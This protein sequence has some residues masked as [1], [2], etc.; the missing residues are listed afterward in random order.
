MTL[1]R[2]HSLLGNAGND[3]KSPQDG[4]ENGRSRAKN[5][6][7][8]SSQRSK[9]QTADRRLNHETLEKRELLAAEIGVE[10]HPVFAPGTPMETIEAWEEEHHHGLNHITS[11]TKLPGFQFGP[12]LQP[13]LFNPTDPLRWR[14][15]A[16]NPNGAPDLGDPITLTWSIVPDGTPMVDPN[17]GNTTGTSNL[18][19]FLDSVYGSGATNEITEKPW[20]NIFANVYDVWSYGTGL[21][22]VYEDDDDQAPWAAGASIGEEDI[23]AD[24][25]IAGAPIDGDYNVLAA[26]YPPYGYGSN[27]LDGDMII[28]TADRYYQDTANSAFDLNI[29]LTNILAHEIGHGL[30]LAHVMPTNGTKL[31]EPFI[32][33]NYYG[34]QED[35][36][37]NINMLYGDALEPNDSIAQAVP[38]GVLDL[39][40][41]T[42]TDLT[43]DGPNSDIDVFSFS[44]NS[45]TEIDLV[46]T[47][48]GSRYEEGEQ[49][50]SAPVFVDRLRQQDLQFRLLDSLG[51]EI[52]LSN[53][54]AVGEAEFRT[55]V[56][57]AE[58]DYAIEVS[59]FSGTD[60]Q[61][62]R[63]SVGNAARVLV[64]PTLLAIRPDDSGLLQDGDTLNVAPNEFNLYFNGGADLDESSITTDTVKLIRA[65]A[66]G[67]FGPN[68][69]NLDIN[70]QPIDDDIEVELGYVGLLEAG[71]IEA[72][73]LQQIILR[74]ASSAAHNA[75]D[76]AFS[77][78]DDLYKIVLVGEGGSPL[79]SRTSVPF[80]GGNNFETTFRLN[81]GSQVVAVVPQP[82]VRSNATQANPEGVLS[83]Q[84]DTIVVHFDGQ[85]LDTGDAE[86]PAFYRLIDTRST[87]DKSDDQLASLQPNLA[88]YD[89]AAGTVTLQFA[90]PIPEGN[91]RLDIGEANTPIGGSPVV[92][93]P[94][95]TGNDN[96]STL[97]TASDLTGTPAVPVTLDST[98][99]R[100]TSQIEVQT[101]PLAQRVGG[102]DEPGHR[103]IQREAHVG[104]D[105]GTNLQLPSATEIVRYYFPSTLGVDTNNQ[106]YINLITEKEKEIVRTI[107]DIYAAV[108]GYEFIETSETDP[109]ADQ[110]MIGKG[111]FRAVSPSLGPDDGVAGLANNTFAILNGSIFNQSNRF[112]GDGF[113]EVMVHEIGHSLGLGHS[114]DIPSVQGAG[115]PN[116]VLPGDHDIV[117]LQRVSPPNSTD[118]DLYKFAVGETG[119]FTAETFAERL[120]MPS[121]LSTVLTLFG[122]K[123]DGTLEVIARN[124][125]YFGNDS[126]IDVELDAGTYLIGVTSTENEDYNPLVSDSGFGGT[127]DGEYELELK[128]KGD[129]ADVLRDVDGTPIDGDRDGTPGG[130]FS[131]YFQASDSDTTVFVDRLNDPNASAF[132]G[133]GTLGDAFDN[134][135]QALQRA[136]NRIVFPTVGLDNLDGADTFEI[137]QTIN[138]TP[139]NESFHFGGGGISLAPGASPED[140][141]IATAAAIDAVLPG[142]ATAVGRTVELTNIDRLDLAGSDLLL[143]TP[144]LVR[145]VGNDADGDPATTADIK[146][147]LVGTATSGAALRDGAEFR[148]PQGVTAMIDAGALIKMR[149]SNLD[150]GSSSID[151]DRSAASLQLLGTPDTPVWLRSYFDSTF[152][153]NS[154]GSS[155]PNPPSAGDFGGIVFR[156]DS[157]L[158]SAGMFLNYISHADI[159]HGGGKVFVDSNEDSFSPI[160]VVDARPT[161]AF[162]QI[163]DSNSAAV[164]ASPDS[165][166]ESGGRIGPDI[167]GNY[168]AGNTINGL[169]IRI[170]TEDGEVI[171]KLTTPG[172]FNDTDIAHVLTENLVIAGNVGGRYWDVDSS[173]LS[174]RASGRLLVDPGI[175]IKSSGSR[176]EAEAGGS[177]I[178]AEGTENRPVI[179]TSLS[180][181]RYGGSG[182]F[183]TTNTPNSAG[184]AGDWGG[185]YF[186]YTSSGSIDNA[187]ISYGGGDS[188]IEGGSANFNL[189][190]IHQAEVRI[191]NSLISDNADGNA[192][193]NRNGRGNNQAATI[194]VRGSQPIIV[195]NQFVDNAGPSISIN[196]NSLQFTNQPD[197]GRST[198]ELNPFS[199]FDDNVGPL[200]RLNQFENNGINGMLVRGEILTTETIWDDTDIVHVLQNEIVV[201]NHHSNSGLTLRSSGSESLVVKLQG[202]NAGFTA[203]GSPAEIIDRIGGTVTVSGAPGFPVILTS[204]QDDSVGAGFTPDGAF[205][206]DT[207]NDG[208]TGGQ[209]GDWRGLEFDEFSNDRNVAVV[210]ERETPLT[211]GKDENA[212]PGTAQFVGTLAPNQKSGDENRRLGFEIQGFISPDSS[213]DLDV[214]SFE[215]TAGTPVWLDIDRT[216][217]SLDS[218]IE[219]LNAN[220]TVI[221]RSMSSFDLGEA[222]TLNALPL[223]QNPLLGGD[224]NSENFRDPGLHFVLP[225]TVGNVGRYFVRVRS[226]GS[227]PTSLDGVSSGQYHMQIRLQQ[228]DEYPGS[229]VQYAD[230]RY[231]TR[232]IDVSGL[233]ARSH[234]LGEAGEATAA[235]N[236]FAQAQPLQSLLQSDMAAIS[237][238]GNLG[239]EQGVADRDLDV[240]WYRFDATQTG[241]QEISGVNDAAGTISVVFDMDYADKANRGDT[242]LA[243]YDA[244]GQLIF[245]GR[246]SNIEDDQPDSVDPDP[247]IDDLS[248]GSLGTK[249][250]YIGPVHLISGGEYYIAVMGNG[251]TPNALMG[252]YDNL[253]HFLQD[254]DR[255][256]IADSGA[257]SEAGEIFVPEANADNRYVRLE[258]VNSV[259]RVVEDRIGFSGYNTIPLDP[260]LPNGV[261]IAPQTSIFNIDS[262]ADLQNHLPAF[263]LENV[264]LY[265]ATDRPLPNADDQLYIADPFNGGTYTKPVSPNNW[266]A[267]NDDIQDITIRSDGRMFG[268]Q[269][270]S[271]VG[272]SV[273]QLVE[274]NPANGALTVV[275][276]D[277]IPGETPAINAR[278]LNANLTNNGNRSTV[279][280]PRLEEF[281]N[282]D[283]VDALTFERTGSIT[284]TPDYDL[285]Y[286]V[287]ESSTSS[288]L[289]RATSDGDASPVAA[290][291]G[292]P[293]SNA[294]VKYGVMGNINLAGATYASS[295]FQVFTNGNNIARTNIRVQ[296]NQ[297]GVVG[298]FT[299]N[300]SRPNNG[301]QAGIGNV[302]LATR[303][304]NLVIGTD[305]NNG[306]PSAAAIVNAI[307]T[308]AEARQLVT[309]AIY[310]GNANNNGDGN[311]GTAANN[312]S[313]PNYVAGL[314]ASLQGRVT[315][316]SFDDPVEPTQMYGVTNAGE[317]ITIDK[318]TG[319][320]VILNQVVGQQFSALTL[321]PQSVENGAYSD[322]LFAT[323]TGGRLYAFDFTGTLQSIFVGGSDFVT[324]NDIA[325]ANG[326][327][328]VGLAFSPLDLNLWHPTTRRAN[329]VGHGINPAPDGSRTPGDIDEVYGEANAIGG[330]RTF[331]QQ[332]GG[333]S[334]Y[335]GLEEWIAENQFGNDTQGYITYEGLENAQYGL[336]EKLHRDLTSNPALVS[337]YAL[338]GGAQGQLVSNTFDLDGSIAE[339]RPTLYVNYFLETENHPGETTAN[340]QDPFRDAARVFVFRPSTNEWELVATNNSALSSADPSQT[341][342]GELPGFISHL[343]DAGLNSTTPRAEEHQIVQ[344]LFDN[345]GTWRQARIDLSSFA[346]EVGLQLRFD[347]ST[348]GRIAGD[349]IQTEFGEISSDSRANATFDNFFEGFYIDDI[350]VGYAERGE[351]VTVPDAIPTTEGNLQGPTRAI[352][353]DPSTFQLLNN[354]RFSNQDPNRNPEI[355]SGPYQVEIRRV[356]EYATLSDANILPDFDFTFQPFDTN[357]RHILSE[358]GV[359]M[360]GGTTGLLADQ[361]R[362]RQQGMF[363]IDSNFITDSDDVGISVQPGTAEETG[364]PHPG[365]LINF[366]QLNAS[367]LVPGV[368]IQNNVIAGDSAIRFEGEAS[369]EAGRPV[370]FG[371][372]VNNTLVGFGDGVGI[373]VV[374]RA[375]PTIINNI[376]SEFGTAIDVEGFNATNTVVRKNYFQGNASNGTTGTDPELAGP[377]APL[378]IDRASRNFYLAAGS[379]AIDNSQETLPDRLDFV[380]FKTELGISRSNIDAPQ[381]DV[382]GQLRV[383]SGQSG[384][385][386][387]ADPFIDQ[388]AIDRADTDAPYAVL[389]KPIDDDNAG[390]DKDPNATV[391][392]L[393][394]PILD[395]FSILIGDGRDENSPFEGTGIDPATVD[396]DSILIRRNNIELVE[397]VDYRLGFNGSTGELRLTPL[398]TLWQPNGVYEIILDNQRIADRAGNLLRPNQQ[399]G[400][401]KF[402]IILPT[403]DLDFGDAHDSFGT[404]LSSNG[405]RHAIIDNGLIR[406]GEKIDAEV[407]APGAG[408]S[409][410]DRKP[411]SIT[412]NTAAFQS[413]SVADDVST[414][415]AQQMPLL[416]DTMTIDIGSPVGPIT[417]E[418]VTV[419]RSAEPG[420]LSIVFDDTVFADPIDQMDQ[421]NAFVSDVHDAIAG[422]FEGFG[423]AF[424]VEV[425]PGD[426]VA[427]TQ[428]S[429]SLTNF[430]DEDGVGVGS[431]NT[432]RNITATATNVA[433]VVVSSSPSNPVSLQ[434]QSVPSNGDQVVIDLGTNAGSK[435]FEF[436]LNDPAATVPQASSSGTIAVRY[437][438][439]DNQDDI[440]ARLA[441]RIDQA[442]AGY[443]TSLVVS[444][445]GSVVTLTN[446][447]TAET[448]FV[449]SLA[450]PNAISVGVLG[451]LNPNNTNG[452]SI[453]INAPNGGFL[454][455]WIDWDQN[456]LF[457][458]RDSSETGGEQIFRSV[459]LSAGDNILN[460]VT[461]TTATAGLTTARFRISP[462]GGLASDGLAVGGEVEDYQ[463][464]VIP[465]PNPTPQDDRYDI[466]EDQSLLTAEMGLS[467]VFFG[468]T[469]AADDLLTPFAPTTVVLVDGPSHADS[470]TIDPLT[471]HFS[472]VPKT[473]FAGIDTFT[474]RLADQA[475]LIDNPVL[476]INGNPIGIATVTINVDP[477]N[478]V[479]SVE[480]LTLLALEDTQRTFTA[481]Q[482]KASA[483]GDESRDFTLTLPD[484]ST[485]SAPWDESIQTFNVIALHTTV[486]GVTTDITSATTT[487]AQGFKTP[488]GR[489][490]PNWDMMTG[491]LL[492]VDYL[493]DTDLNQDNANG[494]SLLRDD[495]QF[496]IEDDGELINPGQDLVD[497]SDDTTSTGP[498]L[499]ARA[500]AEIDVKPKNDA[501]VAAEDVI[502]ENNA[503]W[504]AFFIGPDPMNPVAPVPVPTEDQT[505]VI[506]HAY[507]IA[508]DKE[509][510]D[511]AAD[512]N[513]NT[514]DAGLT[515]TAVS[516]TSAL[517][518]TVSIDSNGDIVYTPALNTYGEDSFTYTVTDSGITFDLGP[519][520]MP[521][522]MME[523]DDFLSHTATVRILIKPVNDTPQADDLSLDLLEYREDADVTGGANPDPK[524]DGVGFK[525][526]SKDDLLRLGDSGSA[527]EVTP[528]ADFPADF[529][530]DAQDLRVIKI[531]LPDAA[532]ASVDARL[533]TYDAVTGLAPVQTLTTANGTLTLTFS[534]VAD[535]MNPG[536]FIA[537]SGE[538]VSGS[539]EPNVDYNEESPFDT[540]DLF[541]YF[542][543][544]FS[545]I[546]VP[547]AGNF[548]GE[549]LDSVGHGSLTSEAATVTMTT[550][551]TNDT[552][553]FPVF[554]TVTF[555]EDI[556]DAGDA[557]NTVIYDIYGESVIASADPAVHNLPQAIFV[558]RETAEDERGNSSGAPATQTLTY[559]YNP[560]Y[561]PAGMFNSDP[562]LDE[563]GVLTLT[564]N[565]DAYGYALYEVTMTDNGQSYDPNTGMLVDDFRSITRTLTIHITPVNDAPVTEDR[566]LEVMEVEEFSSPDDMPTGAVASID[567]TPEQ[568]L[569]GTTENTELAEQSDFTDD[570]DALDEFD[571]EEQSLRVVEF[572]VTLADGSTEVVNAENNNGVELTLATGRITFNFDDITAGGAYTGGTYFPNVDY[573]EES[574]FAPNEQFTYVV[575][576]FGVT[577]IPGSLDV[578]GTT[579]QVDYTNDG[580]SPPVGLNNRSTPRTMTLTTRAQ[581]DVPEFPIFGEVSFAEDINDAGDAFNTVFYDIYGEAVIA[582]ADPAVH[583]LPQAI[584]VS[585]ATAEDERGNDSGAL[586]TQN[587]SFSFATVY[588]PDGMFETTPTL[589]EYGVL[590]LTPRADAYGYAVFVVTLTDDGGSYNLPNDPRSINRTLTVHITPVNDAPVTFDR[591]LE[592]DEV[593]EFASPDDSPTGDVASI[594]L[595][596][597]QFL[598]GTTEN[599]ELAEQSDF[600][601][602]IDAVDEF[603]E[604]EQS[605]RVVEFTVT[606][607]DGSTEVVNA[608]NNNGVELT[609]AT[610]RI[611]FNFDDITAGGAY[612]GG[613]YFPN[614]DYNEE[615]PFAP[616]EQFTYVVEDFGTTSI[617]GS[618]FVNAGA[619]DQVDYTNDGGSPPVGLNNRST[620]RTMTLTTRAQNDVPEFP[621]FN[622]VTFAEDINDVGD[623]FNTVIYDIYG[624]SVIASAD[625]AVHNLPQAIF[626][627]RDTA[628]DERGNSSGAPA[629]QTLTYSYNPLY[630]PAG[631]FNSDP[632]LDEYGVLTLTPNADAY[633]YA[634]YEVTMTDNGQSYDPNTG[635][636]VDDFR[637][638]TRTLTIHITPVNDAPVTE[639]RALEVMEVEEFSSPD[640]L[641]TGAVASIDLTPEQFLGGTT[642]N[643]ELAEQSDFTDDMDAVDEFDEEEQSLRVVEFTVTLADGST[644]VVNAE[645][646]NGVEL[647]LLTGRI[648]F[649]FDDITAGGAYTGGIYFPNVDYNEES[650]FAPNEQFTYVVEDFGVTTIPGSL[651][652][653]GTTEQVDYTNDGGSPPVGLNNR[654]TPRT[655][656]LT[657]RAQNDAPEFP[658]FDTVTFAE[659]INDAG[660]AFNT[661]FYDIYSGNVVASYDPANPMRPQ[662]I[663]VSR[664]TALDERGDGLGFAPTQSLSY[665][666]TSLASSS[667]VGMFETLPTLDDFGVL[668]LTPR[669]DVYGW[670]V[671]EVTATDDGSS[672]DGAGGLVS[673]ARSIARTLTINIT[674]VNDQPITFDRDL[675]VTEVEEF[676]APDDL[677]TGAVA[678]LP[679]LP[680]DF[681]G[682]TTANPT[683]ATASDFS[684]ETVTFEEFDEDEQGL[685]VVEFQVRLA[686]GDPLT[687]NAT[688]YVNNTPITLV[689]GTISFEFDPVTGAFIEGEYLPSVDVN[690]QLPFEPTEVFS[691]I[692]EDFDPTSIPG[693]DRPDPD[694]TGA[695]DYTTVAGV[696]SNNRSAPRD[697]TLT[698]RAIN[699]VPEFPEFNTV[700]FAED[701][702]DEGAAFNTVFYDIYAGQVISTNNPLAHGLPQAIHP[703]RATALDERSVQEVSFSV[704]VVSAPSGM[705][706]SD[707]ILDRFGVLQLQPNADAYGY[708]VFTVTATDDGQSYINGSMQDSPRSVTRTLTVN[709]TPVNDQPV[710]Y[711]RELTV[712]EVE[713]FA[714]ITGLPTGRAA[715]LNLTPETFLE[716]TPDAQTA[717]FANGVVTTNE[718][719][720]DEQ[721][722]RVVQF[723]VTNA[724]GTPTVVNRDNLN[725][726]V[727][728]LATGT[729]TFNF[730]ASGAFT[731]GQYVPSVDYNQ[732]SP[733]DPF[734]RFSYIVEDFGATSIPGTDY[735][736]GQM[737]PPVAGFQQSDYT[738][739]GGVG[740]N[741]RSESRRVTI[742]TIQVNDAPRIEFRETV[743][744]R[745]R[746]D[747]RGTSLTD[748]AT[749][750]DPAE[751]TALDENT[752]QDVFFTFKEYVSQSVPDL[753]R[754]GFTPEVSDDGTLTVYPSPDAVGT[755][756]FVMLATD[757][758]SDTDPFSPKSVELTVTVNVRPV[759]DQPRLSDLAPTPLTGLADDQYEI[760]ADGTLVLTIKEDNTA[761]DGTT[762]MPYSIPLHSAGI[763]S[764]PGLLDIYTPGPAN[765][766]DGTLGGGQTVELV[767]FTT[768]PTTLGGSVTYIP[769]NG[770][771]PASLEYTP[772]TNINSLNNLPDSFTYQ[773]IDDGTNFNI[774]DQQLDSSP[775]TRTG[776]I[777][778]VLNP[779]NDRPQFDVAQTVINVSEDANMFVRNDFAFN[780]FGGPTP[781]ASDEFS[782]TS[783]Q[784]VSFNRIEPVN[785]SSTQAGQAFSTLPT[786]VPAGHLTFQAAPGVFG[787][788]VFDIYARDNGEGP[789]LGR[790]D[791]NESLAR[792]ITINVTAV[793]DAPIPANGTGDTITIST[794]EDSA[795][796]I[797][798]DGA[799]NGS[800][801]GNFIAGPDSPVDGLPGENDTQVLSAINV[802]LQTMMGGTLTPTPNGAGATAYVYT[803]PLNFVGTDQFVY[804]VSDGDLS[805]TTPATISLVVTPVNDAPIVSPLAPIVVE[806]S[807]GQVTLP[808]W[809]GTVL[810]GPPG[811]GAGGR[812]VDEFDGTNTT[813]AQTITEYRFAYVSGDTDLLQTSVGN[814]TGLEI[815]ANGSL[816]F[817]TSDENSGSATYQL[818]A[819][820]SGPND[821]ANGDVRESAPVEFTLTVADVN[822]LP[823]FTAGP[824]V[825]VLEDSGAY[826]QPWASDISA[827][828][829][830]EAGQTVAFL[831]QVP[832]EDQDLFAVQ[833]AID[834]N[835]VLTF[836][837]ADDAA[838]S[839]NVTVTLQDFDNG[840]FA[841]S[842][843]PVILP[844]TITETADLPVANDDSFTTTEDAVLFF[845]I[846]DLLANDSDP[847]LADSLNF[848]ELDT[849]TALGATVTINQVTGEIAY[850]PL[851]ADAIQALRPG[852]TLTDTFQYGLQD[853]SA[854]TDIVT[855][856]VTLTI[857]GRND[858][859]VVVNDRLFIESVGTTVLDQDRDPLANDSDIDGTLDR[860]SLTIVVEP[861]FGT[862][863]DDNGV[864]TYLPG[865]D[866]AGVD[867]FTYTIAD[868]LGQASAQATV[869]LQGRPTADVIMGGTSVGRTG[870]IDISDSFTTAFALDLSTIQIITQPSNGTADV[871]DGMIHYTPNAGYTGDDFLVFTVA[872]EN[873]NRS[874]PTRLNL[875]TVS[876]RL[877]NPVSFSDVNRNGEVT[878]LDALLIINR[879]NEVSGSSSAERIPVTDDDYGIGTN[880]GVDEQFYYDQS[881]DSFISSLDALRVI[882]ELNSQ[883]QGFGEPI[884]TT[885][886]L[887]ASDNV[888]TGGLGAS[889]S[890]AS[891]GVSS[892]TSKWIDNSDSGVEVDV[893]NLIASDQTQDEQEEDSNESQLDAALRDLF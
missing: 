466:L 259:D 814:P 556:N 521:G 250:P 377:N 674:P 508:N 93:N 685:R 349:G 85:L 663:F 412:L 452:A 209:K 101:I 883:T 758:V 577:T 885:S 494:N 635:M 439:S 691:Y 276:Q 777:Q 15:S 409:D 797:P 781:T 220:G 597:A 561:V 158:E 602:D 558:S 190:E 767:P 531:G 846:D 133:D 540:T 819:V 225:G 721:G 443:G 347:F 538:F 583:N 828:P 4:R 628:E 90:G 336:S 606:L 145:I 745:E 385:G 604:E 316:I 857:Q 352:N 723:T 380:T 726:M 408:A 272:D 73:N 358:D 804:E 183:D 601:D 322:M 864:L 557:F 802:P 309:A 649:N 43:I 667:P 794:R 808:D 394:N 79:Q 469:V 182:V 502:S 533:L 260:F 426:A 264:P 367:R 291:G 756:V 241:V 16:L 666:F 351:M 87:A 277:N 327:A 304:I 541:T 496:T 49:G 788:F 616:N 60:A 851:D 110:L 715:V 19:S 44:L 317:F 769:E 605:L 374:G 732:E 334:F 7:R 505:L 428:P 286:V 410:D 104:Y 230:I 280:D 863:S 712:N 632:V 522:S 489:I 461:P 287:R 641:P 100:I 790:G 174:A 476:D 831:V 504:N 516:A 661:V 80:D 289:Y 517:G 734:E 694:A 170:E 150:V 36:L 688:N 154:T 51:N 675:E 152:G 2:F 881:G 267:A 112:F 870:V 631:M 400:S 584:F 659:D 813:A 263:T 163:T 578:T 214:Y 151:I 222:G 887:L 311:D 847:D 314:G 210:R 860:T 115:L 64:G 396:R 176:I 810:V 245:V 436:L 569:G 754:P 891:E 88:T 608:E 149:K 595:T 387:G 354:S 858:A 427:T 175:V 472:Y 435:T 54:N 125:R 562:V 388:G 539:Y 127:T 187:I 749:R 871:I 645:N 690:D 761:S 501:P 662:A 839:T 32:S 228:V 512:E 619:A 363:I 836:T 179:F 3:T 193:G 485:Q 251:V 261:N 69:D 206:Y 271:N 658:V 350:I 622:T 696:G 148:V 284:N 677:P 697:M 290:D 575:E 559:S 614:V 6:R 585:R 484:G 213:D 536:M 842:S 376:L 868:D 795:L 288:K 784:T 38:L 366:P 648:T 226:L 22:F 618:Q 217:T 774:R 627:S 478:D 221:A 789:A 357:D 248:R 867:N 449:D 549:S 861:Q 591:A 48:V 787:E 381:R 704:D 445:A 660:D 483:F 481:E 23:R 56:Q 417:F 752:R 425:T 265:V 465:A 50:G 401:T 741:N 644:E 308:H 866:F 114:Y 623:A 560:L 703:S 244:N 107:F 514:N 513:D 13:I 415:V 568:F 515:V 362:E 89:I 24:M 30:G 138:G 873:G 727:I 430:D 375:A 545:E 698:V 373:D 33:A 742:R 124:D 708:A 859:P 750:R 103:E 331:S 278:N 168:L 818:I 610:G 106:P 682:G 535:P 202:G 70:G 850:S 63:L 692:V 546:P 687:I 444:F 447:S 299:L 199:Q 275:S 888:T 111:D 398:T 437:E 446:Q 779:V 142:I 671:F 361:N 384:G 254:D 34:P 12:Q 757:R 720:E 68:P 710:A 503:D 360:L 470:F 188:S 440:A 509:A 893:L 686:N 18:V 431:P 31:M 368:V 330:Q 356:D 165:F 196:A 441:A 853:D 246:E 413:P 344:E 231:A 479:P 131:F 328:P 786:I 603:D 252:Q 86:N 811:T 889:S 760:L 642:E 880:N 706:A 643:T 256:G 414:L 129:S 310:G 91:Y 135:G 785:I 208:Q 219:V 737:N 120:P 640:D 581:N 28:D 780:I 337:T 364:V 333:A 335:F 528:P 78:P 630:V 458:P 803:P 169:F 841:G 448:V 592:V 722:L 534:L 826:S 695:I 724:S 55:K 371:R 874:A 629:T 753:F 475:T 442:L 600:T 343:S 683:L 232:A 153:G 240:D 544:D 234:I 480:N 20:F 778:F 699:D 235:N 403:I 306:G 764:R 17:T 270:L 657:T 733:F 274:I 700:T 95:L 701:I 570:I 633:G 729:V 423:L 339:D 574:P 487:P 467:S 429:L 353:P 26:N 39:A 167:V 137:I 520:G 320:A 321:G 673:D 654:S 66:D 748:W 119:R 75:F 211:A 47:P 652:V 477:V 525:N 719:D 393:D 391:V 323:T 144:N 812:A 678:R 74:P 548:P 140:A 526:F 747:N 386:S 716:G 171:S 651:D 108:S 236:T 9:W 203:T 438:A 113:T 693:A 499:T 844:I 99:V 816:Q 689:S 189:F 875:N 829:G 59:A 613:T 507:L 782:L 173:E 573:N 728:P 751:S 594:D 348:A 58:G 229:T 882:N 766:A 582:S 359:T 551:A 94:A 497:S 543:E 402:T 890:T 160:H 346:G 473:D 865:P 765:E 554:N 862:L 197:Y 801:L 792:R 567:L 460:I 791:L 29:E 822:D 420:N 709:I 746:D 510:R 27:G 139:V 823:T 854:L 736:N 491:Y 325:P 806:E 121:G 529:D 772:P 620:P 71:S 273:G 411:V 180:D 740:S 62:Y 738:T 832:A 262:V 185:F 369:T 800:M 281:T 118:I 315:G 488:R 598:G 669:A 589:D 518:G 884:G 77:F 432:S 563:Y 116:D 821:A 324:L 96:N 835:G 609:L 634:L 239:I 684:D 405:A 638:I 122:V 130:V 848:V 227:T 453:L 215:G 665:T 827:G 564:P 830:N 656:T 714:P 607:A 840:V 825:T 341:P 319:E 102:S 382:F 527:L 500:T 81:R 370:P 378:F 392:S 407:D 457:D 586:P 177:A 164:S 312:V 892:G 57:L 763:N 406:L 492:D 845:S 365:S 318:D 464:E 725:G 390:L 338:A 855:A 186:G 379:T 296:S 162:N 817:T 389:L 799:I 571:E 178:I 404:L 126:F 843:Q 771:T 454:D 40:A 872:D 718:F 205:L 593:E 255:D 506:P 856:N 681:L 166:D 672:Y 636:L 10:P 67:V 342:D 419:G 433:S 42:I 655:M 184:Q 82:V 776:R 653:T 664:N 97:V 596:P 8:R 537:D 204:L 637:S 471:G 493:A 421:L 731:S 668:T 462:E 879:L 639:D 397:G 621:V 300:I 249:D 852:E 45:P 532:G 136:G 212:I 590:T 305:N 617:P 41:Q 553:E 37:F 117:H 159:R 257:Q 552:P 807:A 670:A 566:A 869:E 424:D 253:G 279:N 53:E 21:S 650:P 123:D 132:D 298:N 530:E 128:F 482:L 294:S 84:S 743:D 192:T 876:S 717:D 76:P 680:Q 711:D 624:G 105:V 207:G 511:S 303:T 237:I 61:A 550:H 11:G 292:G 355:L 815:L 329:D 495:F 109:G 326:D 576:D 25:R 612:T 35:D 161:I 455:A 878:A 793:N 770:G 268:Y 46:V 146:P 285:Y 547:G 463:V 615:S 297:P 730:D 450:D 523:V 498:K 837:V 332:S 599:T 755:G 92:P 14:T 474:Y 340:G 735:I 233:P 579:E 588:E 524:S 52:S 266:S 820:D 886:N 395:V 773:V 838:G 302:N 295:S 486:G 181:D 626:V 65:G 247:D 301:N 434:I 242:T 679:L 72:S 1:R 223:A 555:A 762:G 824:A 98:G 143:T 399:D 877:Q 216:D 519:E 383:D 456:G 282:S 783:A 805:R 611:T 345:T 198:G 372:I 83:Q 625:P 587:L 798:V 572:T 218:V 796:N 224:F 705:F 200:V 195:A 759:N 293:N 565:A 833:P 451:Y 243:V 283:E 775:L 172:R 676:S 713:E 155:A 194:Y 647:T 416:K 313:A 646:N 834:E 141:A 422:V 201:G 459:Q 744:I 768:L 707:P 156:D 258:P 418:F 809:L 542:V 157:D 134:I 849:T 739:V 5:R 147:Y 238:A 269:R 702:N 580:G 468:P 191:T 307:N 490:F